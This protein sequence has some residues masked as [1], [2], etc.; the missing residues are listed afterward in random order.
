MTGFVFVK[1]LNVF[2]IKLI[3]CLGPPGPK[4]LPGPQGEAGQPGQVK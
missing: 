2:Y 4:G 1:Q 3:L